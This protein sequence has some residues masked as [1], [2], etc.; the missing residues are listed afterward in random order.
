M[1]RIL[2]TRGTKAYAIECDR[3][4]NDISTEGYDNLFDENVN[5]FVGTLIFSLK[6]GVS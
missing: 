4:F 6:M 2:F 3:E 1:Y 5:N